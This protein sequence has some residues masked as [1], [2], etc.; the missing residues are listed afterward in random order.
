MLFF[1]NSY[2]YKSL[3]GVGILFLLMA[4]TKKT[5]SVPDSGHEYAPSAIGKYVIYDVDSTVYDDFK[6]DTTYYKYRIK[7]KLEQFFTDNEGRQAIKLVRYI[8]TYN[9]LV[10]YNDI[11][12][13]IKDVWSYTK[14]SRFLEVVEEDVRF[15]KLIFPIKEDDTWNGNAKNTL[16]SCEYKYDYIDRVEVINGMKMDS[17]LLVVQKNDKNNVIHREYF[18][19]KYA[20]HIG[21]VYREI[22]DLYSNTVIVNPNGGGIIPV[23]QR[24]Q[25]GVIYKLTYISHGFE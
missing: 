2:I 10:N 8:K 7:E 4:C 24:I 16:G 5:N 20:K 21:L 14:T 11:P 13:T 19:E 6:K 12:W 3:V 23:E 1:M 9:P 22:K 17:M 15:T 25:K 18:V